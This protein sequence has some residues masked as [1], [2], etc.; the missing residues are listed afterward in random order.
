MLP[1]IL[2]LL[3]TLALEPAAPR[4]YASTRPASEVR[5]ERHESIDAARD[6]RVPVKLYLPV[7]IDS[8]RPVVLLSHGLGGSREV[9]AFV[10]DHL[11]SNGY[12][13]VAMQHVGSDESVW[14]GRGLR[15]M[16]DLRAAANGQQ[17]LAR[18][19]DVSFV[20]DHLGSLAHDDPTWKARLDLDRVGI[21][22]HSFGAHTTLAVAGVT[23]TAFGREQTYREKRIRAAVAYSPAPLENQ[24]DR[25]RAYASIEIPI[26]HMTGTNDV[27]SIGNTRAEDRRVPFDLIGADDQY[28]VIL[29]GG[30]HGVFSGLRW[31]NRDARNDRRHHALIE[32][33]TLAFFDAHLMD[34]ARA[35]AWL[36]QGEAKRELGRDGTLEMK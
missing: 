31:R 9:S 27:A 14:R 7:T 30:D 12:V 20:L 2:C 13:V 18:T 4:G 34:D 3:S 32:Q 11:A 28:L 29:E 26:L 25:E 36:E 33:F 10:G 22:G 1:L 17:Y 35:E 23:F 16:D 15:A 21:A 19:Q 24:R 8:P 5:V 6:R